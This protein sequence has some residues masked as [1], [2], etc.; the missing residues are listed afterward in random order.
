MAQNIPLNNRAP[1]EYALCCNF[2]KATWLWNPNRWKDDRHGQRK[3]LVV[4]I[5]RQ[6]HYFWT[7]PCQNLMNLVLSAPSALQ[8]A[9]KLRQ[10]LQT[11]ARCYFCTFVYVKGIG[12]ESFTFSLLLILKLPLIY[13][14]QPWKLGY[15]IN[16]CVLFFY[17]KYFCTPSLYV[18]AWL[19]YERAW[20]HNYLLEIICK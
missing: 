1:G 14:S 15:K 7:D 3:L 10:T 17:L 2:P 20:L 5:C 19:V 18:K 16:G 12:S 4:S 6:N 9:L 8:K 13:S 11:T